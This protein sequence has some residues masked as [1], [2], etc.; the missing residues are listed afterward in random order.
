MESLFAFNFTSGTC[1]P[2]LCVYTEG[3]GNLILPFWYMHPTAERFPAYAPTPET[4]N[5]FIRH[6]F[7]EVGGMSLYKI[8]GHLDSTFT[9]G[10]FKLLQETAYLAFV[11]FLIHIAFWAW[12]E[13]TFEVEL[14]GQTAGTIEK[15]QRR[16]QL[17]VVRKQIWWKRLIKDWK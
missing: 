6:F 1:F 14:K 17:F 5:I 11:D 8:R 10:Y 2:E 13:I 4:C 12:K 3:Y 9:G 7:F 16:L 15:P